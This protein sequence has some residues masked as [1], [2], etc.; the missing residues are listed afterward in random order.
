MSG[1]V[2]MSAL[3]GID[4]ALWD[5][6]GKVAGLPLVELLGGLFRD[7]VEV[8]THFGGGTPEES[9]AQARDLVQRGFSA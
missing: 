3:S 6:K 4:Q 8:Y 5:I 7:R 9:A 1:P 2:W